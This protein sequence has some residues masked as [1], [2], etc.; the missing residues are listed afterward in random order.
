MAILLL[1]VGCK[2]ETLDNNSPRIDLLQDHQWIGVNTDYDLLFKTNNK[3]VKYYKSGGNK[4]ENEYEL[5][6]DKIILHNG[7]IYSNYEYEIMKCTTDSF[8]LYLGQDVKLI[9]SK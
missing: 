1:I 9:F 3:Y 6:N 4:Y 8:I 7:W 2:K 5:K